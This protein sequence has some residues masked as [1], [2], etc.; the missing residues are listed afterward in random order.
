MTGWAGKF[1]GFGSKTLF[2]NFKKGKSYDLVHDIVPKL[3]N[4]GHKISAYK[5]I[6][7]IKDFGTPDRIRIVRNFKNQW[8]LLESKNVSA[9]SNSRDIVAGSPE[10]FEKHNFGN[11]KTSKF[12]GKIEIFKFSKF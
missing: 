5:T 8:R 6:E 12:S 9:P 11:I 3:I 4:H 7:Y 10:N 1:S 2:V